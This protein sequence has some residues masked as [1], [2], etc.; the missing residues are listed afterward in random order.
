MHRMERI[1]IAV[2]GCAC[3]RAALE[4]GAEL[5]SRL[6]AEALVLHVL[7]DSGHAWSHALVLRGGRGHALCEVL[8]A[9]GQDEMEE[10]L[11]SLERQASVSANAR[12][13]KELSRAI[14]AAAAEQAADLLVVGIH[15]HPGLGGL[16]L[17]PTLAERVARESPCPTLAVHLDD[18]FVHD[19]R[20]RERH[21]GGARRV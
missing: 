3:A 15:R 2:D 6:G 10:L 18:A 19:M 17:G 11:S 21:A 13:P 14:V 7:R 9:H 12:A 8:R 4:Y 5:A 16:L 1:V 20:W